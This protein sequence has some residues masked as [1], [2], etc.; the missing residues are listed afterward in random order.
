[1]A[2]SQQIVDDAAEGIRII[3]NIASAEEKVM[4]YAIMIGGLFPGVATVLAAISIAQPWIDKVAAYAPTIAAAVDKGAP[5]I[6]AIRDHAPE[7]MDHLK[8]A[9]ASLASAHPGMS[10]ITAGDIG[11]VMAAELFKTLLANSFFGNSNFTPQDARF[12]RDREH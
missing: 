12:D 1:M 9:Y 4:P 11:D 6:D 2:T 3:G 5:V 8:S 7:V 10:G